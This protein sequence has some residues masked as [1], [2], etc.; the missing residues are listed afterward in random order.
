MNDGGQLTDSVVGRDR[1]RIVTQGPR[2]RASGFLPACDRISARAICISP[3]WG[4]NSIHS[5][6]PRNSELFRSA[7]GTCHSVGGSL[8]VWQTHWEGGK[9]VSGMG[10]R[11]F[12][13]LLGGV[14]ASWPLEVRSQQPDKLPTI[15]FLGVTTPS[16]Q[17]QRT[18]AFVQR[19]RQLGWIE[20]R[21]VAIEYRW[22][23]GRYER[24]PEI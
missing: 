7:R 3:K 21:T 18:T 8:M 13:A 5:G 20:G 11:E 9:P 23:E 2:Y 12:V 19:L 4:V 16:T 14:A 10:R 24:F 6:N 17:T 15:G 22:A 1:P